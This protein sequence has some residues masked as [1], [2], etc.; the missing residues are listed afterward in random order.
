MKLLASGLIGAAIL[1]ICSAWNFRRIRLQL[2]SDLFTRLMRLVGLRALASCNKYLMHYTAAIQRL[3]AEIGLPPSLDLPL[4]IGV[5]PVCGFAAAL[6]AGATLTWS[7][8]AAI[9]CLMVFFAGTALPYIWL[10][11]QLARH[12]TELLR[13]LPDYLNLQAL[14]LEAGLDLTA[15][16]QRY[17]EQE[18]A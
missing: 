12:H 14:L 11:A 17:L 10:R 9:A 8:P 15:G 16:L 3:V 4:F 6:A 7:F 18:R 1:F 13:R 5:H 2:P